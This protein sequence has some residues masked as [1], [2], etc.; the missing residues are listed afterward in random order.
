[1]TMI[2]LMTCLLKKTPNDDCSKPLK[3]FKKRHAEFSAKARALQFG[4]VGPY[5]RNQRAYEK[6]IKD[7]IT[8]RGL[9][10]GFDQ[11]SGEPTHIF[12]ILAGERERA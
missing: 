8:S 1:M 3:A 11:S 10:Y 7:N 5:N 12:Q 2:S 6:W 4:E 9:S